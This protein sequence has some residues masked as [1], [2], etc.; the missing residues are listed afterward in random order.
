MKLTD[1]APIAGE[2]SG[3]YWA[4]YRRP[5][6]EG[7][8]R[9]QREL[10]GQL[11]DDVPAASLRR[12]AA[13]TNTIR[14]ASTLS[15]TA[16]HHA[17]RPLIAARTR[18]SPHRERKEGPGATGLPAKRAACPTASR[19]RDR[20]DGLDADVQRVGD[21]ALGP[22]IVVPSKFAC[23]HSYLICILY[24]DSAVVA[25]GDLTYGH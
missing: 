21:V 24:A 20:A 16:D 11:H 14:R 6:R 3:P 5:R 2:P 13:A 9:P 25:L 8:Q 18:P 4:L 7:A 12:L 22:A 17:Q 10:L 15:P 23:I 19:R 1:T